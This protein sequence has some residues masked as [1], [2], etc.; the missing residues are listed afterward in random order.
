MDEYSR[1]EEVLNRIAE[2]LVQTPEE[3]LLQLIQLWEVELDEIL[4]NDPDL[5]TWEKIES[6]TSN[7]I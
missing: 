3:V 2:L 1:R 7:K 4:V 6:A 5:L